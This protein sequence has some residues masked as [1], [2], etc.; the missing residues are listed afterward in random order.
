[1][2]AEP[3]VEELLAT[4]RKA[5]DQDISE[6]DKRGA[7][8]VEHVHAQDA[9][10]DIARLRGRVGRQKLDPPQAPIVAA[11]FVSARPKLEPRS[12]GV[13]AI[14][15]GRDR[16]SAVPPAAI[17]RPSYADEPIAPRS[18]PTRAPI[19]PAPPRFL[20]VPEADEPPQVY[21]PQPAP[22]PQHF[23]QT[24]QDVVW[25]EEAAPQHQQP[26]YALPQHS[27][28]LMSPESAYAAQAS[29]QALS[30]SLMAQL[31]GDGR[32]QDMTRD[33]LQPLLKEWLDENLPSLV[34]KLVREEIE[35]VA[36][37]GR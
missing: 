28:A 32:L 9:D 27:G 11:T 4:I 18:R 10:Q 12:T 34:E 14:L 25:V 13:S 36:R 35:R 31:G 22:P 19:N 16:S 15:S 20:P 5:I 26:H 24:P 30:N 8:T 21:A 33:M 3:R 29:F 1:M 6:L 23:D 2:T 7:V 17:L 37:R